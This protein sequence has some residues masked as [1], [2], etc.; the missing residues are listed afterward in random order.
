MIKFFTKFGLPR[1]LQSDC[2]SN[3]TS[4]EFANNMKELGIQHITSSPYHPESQGKIERFHQTMKS[5]L[6]KYC[7]ESG[8]DWDKELPFVLFAFR[9]APSESLGFSP[10]QLVFGHCVR[11]PLDVIRDCWEEDES[12][13]DLLSY[14]ST[15]GS[16]LS[17]A[18]GYAKDH[19]VKSKNSMKKYY[20]KNVKRRNFLVGER[21]LV[22]LPIPGNPLYARYSGPWRIVKKVNELN[23]LVETPSRR[24][25][26]QLCHVN[27]LK[28]YLERVQMTAP[29]VNVTDDDEK[30]EKTSISEYPI[31]NSEILQDLHV[32]LS[33]L[34]D[35]EQLDMI[36]LLLEHKDLFKD[37]PGLTHILQH[38][39]DIGDNR[40]IKQGPYR[41]NP[42]KNELVQKEVQ[43]MLDHNLA[44]PSNSPWSSPVVLV[45]KERGRQGQHRLCFDYRKLNEATK[46]DSY[47][48]PRVDDCID[49]IG[50]AKYISKLD[51]LKGYWQVGLTPKAQAA[52]A[53]VT[54]DGLF[55][56]KVMPFGMKNASATFQRLMNRITRNL[57]GCIVY[58]DDI[59]IYSDNWETHLER[60]RNLFVALRKAGLAVNLRKSEFAKAKIIYLGHEIG[61][62]NVSPRDVNVDVILN[63]PTPKT[64]KDV[65]SFLGM[66]GY[67]RRFVKNYAD[68][69]KPLTT[70]TKKCVPFKWNKDS[71]KAFVQLKAVLTSY[72]VLASP[73]FDLPFELS[74]DASDTGVGAVLQQMKQGVNHP[75]AYFSKKLNEAQC[76]YSTIEKETLALVLALDHFEIY[77]SNSLNPIKIYTDHNPLVFLRKFKNKSQRLLKWSIILQDWNLDIHLIPGR[78][79]IIP[80]TLSRV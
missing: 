35:K 55:E 57:E 15:L 26:V 45:K 40:P 17:H 56:C 51:L 72:P 4:R 3:F 59:V 2:G 23:Y 24:K 33:H 41:L 5:V 75:V 39:V 42:R 50:T 22:L 11:G 53:F 60:L 12:H 32:Y 25:K 79:N 77:L 74:I 1:I 65:R 21:V 70:L 8:Y 63:F 49:R 6:K 69:S 10:F 34:S 47:P 28:P 9:S 43:Y 61:Y 58:I 66:S 48:L 27:M 19:L 37:N 62:G 44:I 36:D 7:M 31:S 80:D 16:K 67:Y 73:N 18:W 14:I 68:I 38:D 20:D 54:R 46:T 78:N 64:K 30:E 76:K 29:I 71:E 52:S 13:V